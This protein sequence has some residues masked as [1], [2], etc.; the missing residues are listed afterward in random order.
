MAEGVLLN[1][2]GELLKN[3]GSQAIKEIASTWRYKKQLQ[4]LQAT[5]TTI[6][7]AL[8]DTANRQTQSDAVQ[9]WLGRLRDIIYDADDLFDEFAT[10]AAR[11]RGL[12]GNRVTKEVRLFFSSSNQVIFAFRLK[13]RIKEIRETLDDIAKDA[14]DIGLRLCPTE[15]QVVTMGREQTSSFLDVEEVVGRDEDKSAILNMLLSTNVEEN[16]SVISIF[17]V[18]GLGKTTL[19]QMVYKDPQVVEHFEAR[20]W[21]CVSDVFDI[22]AI[23]E[24]VLTSATERK[25]NDLPINQLQSQLQKEVGMKKYLLV[26]DDVWEESRDKW[27]K[28]KSFLPV[29]GVGSKILVT[30]RSQNVAEIMGSIHSHELKGLSETESWSLFAK[31]AFKRGQQEAN[32]KL[33]ELGKQI[34]K[35]CANVPLAIRTLGCLLYGA[36]ERKWLSIKNSELFNAVTTGNEVMNVLRFSYKHLTPELKNCFAFC[37]LFPKDFDLEKGTLINLWIAEGFIVQSCEGQSLE[38]VGEE[39][40]TTLLHRCFFQDIRRYKWPFVTYCKMHDLMHDLAREV[41][42]VQI[43]VAES[44]ETKFDEGVHHVS[45][46]TSSSGCPPSLFGLKSLRTLLI[47]KEISRKE[48][49]RILSLR[50][51]RV[52]DVQGWGNIKSLPRSIGKLVHLRYLDLSRSKIEE[53]PSSIT[54]LHNLQTL[55]LDWC[56]SLK[57]LPEDIGKLTN[58]RHL[59]LS[60]CTALRHMPPGMGKLTELWTLDEFILGSE[61]TSKANTAQLRDLQALDNL[62]GEL[63]ISI[64]GKLKNLM[65]DA[66]QSNLRSKS[67]LVRLQIDWDPREELYDEAVLVLGAL[68]PP[69]NLMKLQIR[70]YAGEGLPS[71]ASV[72]QLTRFLPNLVEIRLVDCKR[73]QNL[74]LFDQLPSLKCLFLRDLESVEYMES[75]TSLSL[76]ASSAAFFPSLETLVLYDMG[77]LRR[78]WKEEDNYIHGAETSTSTS[79]SSMGGA[80]ATVAREQH[81]LPTTLSS[82]PK[83]TKLFMDNCPYMTSMPLFPCVEELE[84]RNVNGNLTRTTLAFAFGSGTAPASKLKRLE[85]DNGEH[86]ISIPRDCLQNLSYLEIGGAWQRPRVEVDWSSIGQVFTSGVLSSLRELFIGFCNNLQSLGGIGLEH[87]TG[88]ESLRISH[89][90]E[91]ELSNSSSDGNGIMPWKALQSLCKLELRDLPKMRALPDGLQYITTLRSMNINDCAGLECL[92]EGIRSLPN[93]KHLVIGECSPKIEERCRKPNGEYWPLIRHI[94]K[95]KVSTEY[96]ERWRVAGNEMRRFEYCSAFFPSCFLSIFYLIIFF[97][98]FLKQGREYENP[99]S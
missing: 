85:I 26:L 61:H 47:R 71:W 25:P 43:A 95:V 28:L 41:A 7:A 46:M 27:L 39:Y 98:C 44:K 91:L 56:A 34:L 76:S 82:F 32:P 62:T 20:L 11:K 48:T 31:M 83:L 55:N 52:L 96:G 57:S 13:Q 67:G 81:H 73:C 93:L 70:N 79:T 77:R 36:D 37:A 97:L 14:A 75:D 66:A 51:L 21:A 4:K 84:L 16:V 49:S 68:Q 86:L 64:R 80:T 42:G 63:K 6:N 58:L 89:C 12:P 60:G 9:V 38:E 2:A 53:L 72:D 17:G 35:K 78:W 54:E 15:E 87:L 23:V 29:G 1:I 94:P 65:A 22:K 69:P 99:P 74:P 90:S 92:P 19:A 8:S 88:L 33:V 3:L 59:N 45:L 30:T 24:R 10:V 50:S 18:G 5:I 40:F